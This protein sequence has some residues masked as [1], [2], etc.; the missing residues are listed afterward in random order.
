M[1]STGLG[2]T[3]SEHDKEAKQEHHH[4]EA[5]M[6]ANNNWGEMIWPKQHRLQL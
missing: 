6:L 3:S 2:K 1:S 4:G 5:K